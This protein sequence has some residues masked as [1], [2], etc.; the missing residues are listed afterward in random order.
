MNTEIK[1]RPRRR[2]RVYVILGFILIFLIFICMGVVHYY[3]DKP[4]IRINYVAKLNELSRLEINE[5][6]NAWPHYQK[7]LE[8]YIEPTMKLEHI[9][10]GYGYG[11]GGMSYCFQPREISEFTSL[12]IRKQKIFRLWLQANQKYLTL[13]SVEERKEINQLLCQNKLSYFP[14]ESIIDEEECSQ[15]NGVNFS[16]GVYKPTYVTYSK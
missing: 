2:K 12:P 6:Q 10:Y 4:K 9:L 14:F 7:A 5:E 13:L 16:K 11:Y 1:F 8:L 3:Q 15:I